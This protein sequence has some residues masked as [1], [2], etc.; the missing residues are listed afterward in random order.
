MGLPA[1]LKFQRRQ[2]VMRHMLRVILDRVISEAQRAGRLHPNIDTHYDIV[3]PEIDV[4]DHQTQASAL[5]QLANGLS[6][7]RQQG[8]VSDETAMRILFQSIGCE[9]DVH[10]ERANILHPN[11]PPQAAQPVPAHA[12]RG[13]AYAAG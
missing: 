2:Q 11:T 13:G 10:D 4:A 7:A 1:L 9:I 8:W 5:N 3:F 12:D 6:V